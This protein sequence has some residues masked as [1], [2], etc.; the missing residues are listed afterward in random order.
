MFDFSNNQLSGTLPN[1][2]GASS[3]NTSIR[4]A[5][6]DVVYLADNVLTGLSTQ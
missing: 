5:P 1:S 2:W 4:G 3:S 6:F